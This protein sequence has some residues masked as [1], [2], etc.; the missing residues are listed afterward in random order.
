V[1]R[2]QKRPKIVPQHKDVGVQDLLHIEFVFPKRHY[3]LDEVIV[4]AAYFIFVKLRIVQLSLSL[5]RDEEITGKGGTE[6]KRTALRT[7]EI[8]DGIPVKGESLPLR[9]FLGGIPIW[10]FVAFAGSTV[11]V[12]YYLRARMVTDTGRMYFKRLPLI[13]GRYQTDSVPSVQ[14]TETVDE[15]ERAHAV[16]EE[17]EA[18]EEADQAVSVPQQTD[19]AD[20]AE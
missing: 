14:E 8:M 13:I 6:T 16:P 11:K 1:I 4:G 2:I 12:D 10:P 3:N 20:D 7:F 15:P 17:A 5:Y 18:A 9:L 19:P